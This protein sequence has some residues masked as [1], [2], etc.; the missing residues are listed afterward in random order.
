VVVVVLLLLPLAGIVVALLLLVIEGKFGSPLHDKVVKDHLV[1]KRPD[2]PF[3]Y[4]PR[5][6]WN[7]PQAPPRRHPY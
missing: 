4:I 5:C 3:N 7:V 2:F 1:Q 6:F